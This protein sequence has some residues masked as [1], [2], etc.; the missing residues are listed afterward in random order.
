VDSPAV[1]YVL[2]KEIIADSC[3]Q[4]TNCELSEVATLRVCLL[5][6]TF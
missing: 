4:E 3:Q 6:R 5:R 1:R 2:K